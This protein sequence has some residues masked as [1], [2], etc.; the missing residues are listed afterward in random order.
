M[1]TRFQD[2]RL[3]LFS[4][5]AHPSRHFPCPFLTSLWQKTLN[6]RKQRGQDFQ[7]VVDEGSWLTSCRVLAE[8][9]DGTAEFVAGFG[10]EGKLVKLLD[11]T[12][13]LSRLR[14]TVCGRVTVKTG[15]NATVR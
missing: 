12:L 5:C 14:L 11:W 10:A 6:F 7:S 1:R 4:L 9:D 8:S 13:F 3:D 15:R 2:F